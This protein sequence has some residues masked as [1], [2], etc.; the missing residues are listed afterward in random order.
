MVCSAL[1]REGFGK[2]LIVKIAG[3]SM[4]FSVIT[5]LAPEVMTYLEGLK[6]KTHQETNYFAFTDGIKLRQVAP[7]YYEHQQI[8]PQSPA[9]QAAIATDEPEHGID[10]S[11]TCGSGERP[12]GY[13][14]DIAELKKQT[15]DPASA[16]RHC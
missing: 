2:V 3:W 14:M 5:T 6:D 16:D 8:Q 1:L 9:N 7:S 4:L 11:T 15:A 12:T 13:R 10:F